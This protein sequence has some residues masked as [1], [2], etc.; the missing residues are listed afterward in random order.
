MGSIF[1]LFG[2]NDTREIPGF[3]EG[4]LCDYCGSP[5]KKEKDA[6]THHNYGVIHVVCEK[7]IYDDVH[8]DFFIND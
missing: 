8:E 3:I 2:S 1:N 6:T 4:Q 7:D 5:I